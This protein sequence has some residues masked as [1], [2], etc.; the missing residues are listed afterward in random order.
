MGDLVESQVSAQLDDCYGF[1]EDAKKCSDSKEEDLLDLAAARQ[2]PRD[3]YVSGMSKSMPSA[4]S[5][6]MTDLVPWTGG[7]A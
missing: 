4:T 5:A 7:K 2:G 6:D 3:K 1:S